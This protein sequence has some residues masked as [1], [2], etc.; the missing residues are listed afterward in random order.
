MCIR[1]RIS[2]VVADAIYLLRAHGLGQISFLGTDVA[3][4][5]HQGP[6]SPDEYTFT[7]VVPQGKFYYFRVLVFGAASAPT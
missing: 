7:V 1:D 5:F 3:N 4:A 6:L 2:D